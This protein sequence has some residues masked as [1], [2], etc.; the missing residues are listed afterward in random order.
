MLGWISSICHS[1]SILCPSLLCS[2][3]QEADLSK[4]YQQAPLSSDFHPGLAD[5]RHE[6]EIREREE[7]E[8]ELIPLMGTS[9]HTR[10]FQMTHSTQLL[11]LRVP[12]TTSSLCPATAP[13]QVVSIGIAQTF[14]KIS[15]KTLKSSHLSDHVWLWLNHMTSW[16]PDRTIW[17]V[18]I[19]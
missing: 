12:V 5:G 18:I 15:C 17:P 6:C 19:I 3:P 14:V 4:P 13:F 10:S 11:Y 7:N 9:L 2:M 1:K 16:Y 8:M